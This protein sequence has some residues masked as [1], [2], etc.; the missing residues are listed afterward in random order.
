MSTA[1]D[2]AVWQGIEADYPPRLRRDYPD[3]LAMAKSMLASRRE[4]FPDLI[5]AGRIEADEAARQIALFEQI[6][7]DWRWI[8]T[9]EGEP[10]PHHTIDDR[11]EALDASLSTIANVARRRRGFDGT[12]AHQAECVIAMRWH[13]DPER[14]RITRHWAALTHQMRREAREA[15]SHA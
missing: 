4:R 5:A 14:E 7:A 15:A 11:R 10:A 9:G 8:C 3:L 6:V 12:L 2:L 1:P 13:L